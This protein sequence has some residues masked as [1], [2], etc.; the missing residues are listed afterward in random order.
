MP[1]ITDPF[2]SRTCARFL[3]RLLLPSCVRAIISH[4]SWQPRQMAQVFGVVST[5]IQALPAV[6]GRSPRRLQ[7]F[8]SR[9]RVFSPS[10]LGD[11]NPNLAVGTAGCDSRRAILEDELLEVCGGCGV[12]PPLA[13][14]ADPEVVS[15][16]QAVKR[17]FQNVPRDCLLVAY[18]DC[19]HYCQ[20]CLCR[21]SQRVEA[22]AF[23]RKACISGPS[24][25]P[26]GF[27]PWPDISQ[28]GGL[29]SA[30]QELSSQPRESQTNVSKPRSR[31]TRRRLNRWERLG[32]CSQ[33][34]DA[35]SSAVDA[36]LCC[37]RHA[38][39]NS[40][41]EPSASA[42]GAP[43]TQ[44]VKVF[45]GRWSVLQAEVGPLAQGPGRSNGEDGP[46]GPRQGYGLSNLD[47]DPG[48]ASP[49]SRHS[50]RTLTIPEPLLFPL[51]YNAEQP[52]TVAN[53][54]WDPC[55]AFCTPTVDPGP[56]DS[57]NSY[58][59]GTTVVSAIPN[60]TEVSGLTH[61]SPDTCADSSSPVASLGFP[62]KIPSCSVR[63]ASMDFPVK[64]P[65]CNLHVASMGFLRKMDTCNQVNY[66]DDT[67]ARGA[68]G[69]SDCYDAPE[70]S[71]SPI[72]AESHPSD[73]RP[74]G[75]TR[76]SGR[77]SADVA[78]PGMRLSPLQATEQHEVSPASSAQV[79]WRLIASGLQ[80]HSEAEVVHSVSCLEDSGQLHEGT[81]EWT[82]AELAVESIQE[83][84]HR[85]LL[86]A[87]VSAVQDVI[88][89]F[90]LKSTRGALSISMLLRGGLLLP[91]GVLS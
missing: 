25:F 74:A 13:A 66:S 3:L 56:G 30:A 89:N 70:P 12:L 36:T 79:L 54:R 32:V 80:S 73:V 1:G 20:N 81:F 69:R 42:R 22:G 61:P 91:S 39:I 37:V 82:A 28:S 2:C 31:R 65:S 60:A 64:I 11:P 44:A 27:D 59:A 83:E 43:R 35:A 7:H 33:Q 72:V 17:A 4:A 6:P 26:L 68:N 41:I 14:S 50:D 15:F 76:N 8:P 55:V 75:C 67:M 10:V 62:A 40:A 86:N 16:L 49:S 24:F 19:G 34:E 52:F 84:K 63:V 88:A 5:L 53:C 45:P 23:Q 48:R 85:P 58:K 90:R 87:A 29:V 46:C 78:D 18:R 47:V 38:T 9:T 21:W 51:P 57:V 71:L 77:R